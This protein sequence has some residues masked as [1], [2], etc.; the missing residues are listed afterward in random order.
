MD[1][2]TA[3]RRNKNKFTKELAYSREKFKNDGFRKFNKKFQSRYNK[4]SFI[5]DF[6]QLTG[7]A[8][9][10]K[11]LLELIKDPKVSDEE[12]QLLEELVA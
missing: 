4:N 8:A 6:L 5:S 7:K 2:A 1:I 3:S 12:K 10:G 9:N 11:T